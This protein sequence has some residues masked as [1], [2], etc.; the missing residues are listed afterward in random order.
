MKYFAPLSIL[1]LCLAGPAI[2]APEIEWRESYYNP[3]PDAGDLILPMP[4]GGAMAFRPVL[5]PN[6]GGTMG[7]VRVTLGEESDDSPYL[8]GLRRSYV[9]GAFDAE[10][11][12]APK[13]LFW[14]GKYEIA[15]AQWD[16]V[17]QD[18]CP[19]KKP[20]KSG[21]SPAVE[22]TPLELAQFAQTYTLW[23]LRERPDALPQAGQTRAYLRL[24]TEDEWEFAARGGLNVTN[25]EFRRPTPPRADGAQP[26]EY[27]AHGGT[28]S[29]GGRVQVIGTLK[30]NALGLH[31]MLGNAG[32]IVGTAFALVRHG[33]LHGQAGGI[34]KRGGDARTPLSDITSATRLEVPPFD[35]ANLSASADRFTGA[36]LAIAGLSI[37]SAD[38]TDRMIEDLERLARIDPNLA[39][40]NSEQEIDAILSDI[41]GRLDSPQEQQQ[42]A[43]IRRTIEA[44]RA[45]RNAQRDRSIRLLLESGTLM[46]DQVVQR[47]L[48]ALAISQIQEQYADYE[49]EARASGDLD[50]LE[51]LGAAKIEAEEQLGLLQNQ[52]RSELS[53][54]AD[55]VEGLSDDY[56]MP[57]LSRHID[58]IAPDVE[59]RGSR[60]ATCLNALKEHL[61]Q[62]AV[63]G[64]A[65][66]E[67]MERE[68]RA[69]ALD[70]GSLD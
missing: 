43:V 34:V 54:Y 59:R 31:D 7:D 9:S 21:F 42:L 41:E 40:A 29:A 15:Q 2:A 69:I 60:R 5:T 12:G 20:R 26:S 36:R 44:A 19:E 63:S 8:N 30:P 51:E 33:R 66:A 28:D 49:A 27:I 58:F 3:Q 65:D 56:S 38:Q 6:A 48:N 53:E 57:L 55:L 68:L 62:R 52:M 24:P 18:G 32:E 67:R 35:L 13:G 46:C 64:F 10:E 1:C 39:S 70:R 4:C 61:Q 23:L 37:T 16:V 17:M 45:D 50:L 14:L 11:G 25:A 22:H 47:L